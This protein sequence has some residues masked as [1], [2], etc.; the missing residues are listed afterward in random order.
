MDLLITPEDITEILQKRYKERNNCDSL[1][2]LT[3]ADID[4][5]IVESEISKF[6]ELF[7]GVFEDELW[8]VEYNDSEDGLVNNITLKII[9]SIK[10][11]LEKVDKEK[12]LKILFKV[13]SKI[14]FGSE[15]N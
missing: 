8:P 14:I 3:K 15:D 11:S 9:E 1:D 4:N 6:S 5:F 12:L 2:N 7:N 13:L 10:G